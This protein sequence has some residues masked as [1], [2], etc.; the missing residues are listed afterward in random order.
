LD[1]GTGNVIRTKQFSEKNAIDKVIGVGIAAHEGQLFGWFNQL[2]GVLTTSGLILMCISAFILWRRRKP[3]D[4]L[5]APPAMPQATVGK[6]VS[7]I[8]LLLAL[9]LPVLAISLVLILLVEWLV[10]KRLK[11]LRRWLGLATS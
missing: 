4:V 1:G 7:A 10:L 11:G 9:V 5:G 2:L 3:K 8:I 6:V